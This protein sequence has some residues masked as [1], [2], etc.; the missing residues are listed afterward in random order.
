MDE[1]EI[2]II[3]GGPAGLSAGIYAARARRNVVL[4]EPGMIG[5]QIAST[6]TIENYPGFPDGVNGLDLAL[7]MQ[8][9]ADAFGLETRAVPVKA[10]RRDGHRFVLETDSG[11]VSC[12]AVIATAGAEANK[13]NVPGE[14]ELVGHGV[15]YCAACD[16]AFFRDVPVA[17]VGGG[18]AA[19]DEALFVARF[20]SKVTI[21]H[22]RDTFR[23]SKILQEHVFAEPKIAI[24]WNTVVDRVHGEGALSSISLRDVVT[25]ASRELAVGGLFVLVGQTPNSALLKG[26]VPLDPSGHAIVNLWMETDVP[27]FFVAGDL[28]ADAARP[29]V[30]AAGDGATA[31]IRADRYL[32]LDFE[33]PPATATGIDERRS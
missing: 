29:L 15:S 5:G 11:D 1:I 18:D 2:G 21:V 17:V 23:A 16:A 6:G 22:R 28:R 25:G 33:H 20:A 4:F 24:I 19:L 8:R 30:S 31:A 9:Q 13:L 3:G 7:A 27:G 12:D 10:I 26:L 14:A 32:T